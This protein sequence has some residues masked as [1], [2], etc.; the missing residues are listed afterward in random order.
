MLQFIY[1]ILVSP[2]IELNIQV[3]AYLLQNFA[4]IFIGII[5]LLGCLITFVL[6]PWVI[7]TYDPEWLWIDFDC[8]DLSKWI[9]VWFWPFAV[10]GLI[11]LMCK[12]KASIH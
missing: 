1:D 9:T 11:Y 2:S 5:Y 8:G 6:M 10:V 7:S 12:D 4:E 3:P